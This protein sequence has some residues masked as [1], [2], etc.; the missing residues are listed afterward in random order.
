M[1]EWSLKQFNIYNN[2]TCDDKW[3]IMS[4]SNSVLPVFRLM[5]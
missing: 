3:I 2:V 4:P 1:I 5:N